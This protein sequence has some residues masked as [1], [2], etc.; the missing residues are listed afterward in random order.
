MMMNVLLLLVNMFLI[1]YV[2]L[3]TLS[4]QYCSQ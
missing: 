4:A 3:L 2:V 1:M